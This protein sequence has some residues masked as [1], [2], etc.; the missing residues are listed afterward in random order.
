MGSIPY[1]TTCILPL[2]PCLVV[3]L[4]LNSTLGVCGGEGIQ[5]VGLEMIL[6]FY[7]CV[8]N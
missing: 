8:M 5:E 6:A 1:S 7:C 4:K 3:K 2:L